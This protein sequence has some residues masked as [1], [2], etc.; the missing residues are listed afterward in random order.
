MHGTAI[1]LEPTNMITNIHVHKEKTC[2]RW[3]DTL[4]VKSYTMDVQ[5][6]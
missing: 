3:L 6:C 2:I 1:K 4:W 5:L